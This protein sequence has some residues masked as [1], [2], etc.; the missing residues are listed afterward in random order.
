MARHNSTINSTIDPVEGSPKGFWHLPGD[1]PVKIGASA[2]DILVPHV[3]EK[4]HGTLQDTDLNSNNILFNQP[5]WTVPKK[6]KCRG[7]KGRRS[8]YVVTTEGEIYFESGEK[9]ITR[10]SFSALTDD[11]DLE[12]RKPT[13][14]ESKKEDISKC[15]AQQDYP[16]FLIQDY[17][18]YFYYYNYFIANWSLF[19][20]IL[21][22]SISVLSNKNNLCSGYFPSFI[23]LDDISFLEQ[24]N[25]VNDN[26][27]RYYPYI[28]NNKYQKQISNKNSK[29]NNKYIFKR[30][31]DLGNNLI[32]SSCS[33]VGT[34][35]DIWTCSYSGVGETAT[36]V[37]ESV[38]YYAGNVT[39]LNDK[40]IP[41]SSSG[42][43]TNGDIWTCGYSGVGESATKVGL[44]GHTS[45]EHAGVMAIPE[46]R[47]KPSPSLGVETNGDIWPCRYSGEGES[48][49][50]VGQSG[51]TR[52]VSISTPSPSP[53][54]GTNG[55]I[56]TCRYSG[57]GEPATI[58]GNPDIR[59]ERTNFSK[60]SNVAINKLNN[61]K[62]NSINNKIYES[63][64]KTK[65]NNIKTI[66]KK[67][68][69]K[70]NNMDRNKY[71]SSRI[72]KFNSNNNNNNNNV[73]NLEINDY[74]H[75]DNHLTPRRGDTPGRGN[76]NKT[77]TQGCNHGGGKW[78]MV[79]NT[80]LMLMV[81]NIDI[82]K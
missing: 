72:N 67:D 50:K 36:K 69:N 58:V 1:T 27:P 6:R 80:L 75:L 15:E 42:V 63:N 64:S 82:V 62:I 78:E 77:Y 45:R 22:N 23:P 3:L 8:H 12:K 70:L 65:T 39:N 28:L 30:L 44:S 11:F 43:G 76:S 26:I 5:P 68:N 59:P 38:H 79:T 54:V 20:D 31:S 41:S 7:R 29:Y 24:Y 73:S 53:G 66:N 48:T 33:G 25:H 21:Y 60:N 47:L 17:G 40:M 16:D 35:G 46:T 74:Q 14:P 18:C 34:N 81:D 49:T 10:N 9:V 56:W 19:S 55:D 4:K 13:I 37:G 52:C 2:P 32:P 61:R 51:N 71:C 57:V